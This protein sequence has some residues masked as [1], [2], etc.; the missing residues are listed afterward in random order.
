MTLGPET[1]VP[2]V[3]VKKV[4]YQSAQPVL[5]KNDDYHSAHQSRI[6][7]KPK[8]KLEKKP[9]KSCKPEDYVEAHETK[10]ADDS[11]ESVD[12]ASEVDLTARIGKLWSGSSMLDQVQTEPEQLN[13]NQ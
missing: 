7:T 4:N 9:I 13:L 6:P 12:E 10:P 1:K 8:K 2:K 11:K 5:V 3:L